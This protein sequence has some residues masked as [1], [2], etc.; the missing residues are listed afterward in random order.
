MGRTNFELTELALAKA[1]MND[2]QM[3]W[4]QANSTGGRP[5]IWAGASGRV[6]R[7]LCAARTGLGRAMVL[8][9]RALLP[10]EARAGL[11]GPVRRPD[12]C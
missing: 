10:A 3:E 1:R 12:N 7:A 4:R 2:L 6:A 11:A 9:G 8:L 5:G